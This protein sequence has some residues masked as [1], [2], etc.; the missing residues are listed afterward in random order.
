VDNLR[1]GYFFIN[2][3]ISPHSYLNLVQIAIRA[4]EFI[5]AKEFTEQYKKLIIG[6]D[7]D[8]FY[9]KLNLAN[10][11]F[12][13]GDFDGALDYLPDSSSNFYHYQA[14]RRLELKIYYEL[15][16]ALLLYKLDSFRKYIE[17]TAP[18]TLSVQVREMN[19]NFLHVLLQLAQS[20]PKDKAR[21]ATLIARIQNKKL[22]AERQWL[23]EKAR[24]L[25]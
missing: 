9:Y 11:L 25:G 7:E 24:E 6:G 16:S 20:P 19:L 1:R 5:W 12:S 8:G 2:G 3:E 17:R 23:L 18:K 4:N 21:S 15:N 13:L 10:C 22:V 14:I